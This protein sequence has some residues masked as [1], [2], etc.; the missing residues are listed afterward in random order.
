M[1]LAARMLRPKECGFNKLLTPVKT[2]FHI[3]NFK[4]DFYKKRN[5][6]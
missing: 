4:N 2:L 5:V 6:F 1:G 3:S